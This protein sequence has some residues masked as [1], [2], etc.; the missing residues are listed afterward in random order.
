MDV[1]PEMAQALADGNTEVLSIDGVNGTDVGLDSSDELAIRILVGDPENPPGGLPETFG[2]FPAIIVAGD[3]V[4]D[5]FMPDTA[6][7][8][9]LRGGY[10][11]G[12]AVVDGSIS[13]GTLGCV[14]R[15]TETGEPVVLTAGHVVCGAPGDVIYQPAPST[16]PPPDFDELGSVRRCLI[17]N[18]PAFFPTPGMTGV[19]GFFDAAVCS[20]VDG[21]TPKVG[22]IEGIGT[23]TGITGPSVGDLV[24][25]RGYK[26][27]PTL[28]RVT[29]A[30]GT[31][32]IRNS[33]ETVRWWMM[34]Q[35]SIEAVPDPILNPDGV[36]GTSGDSGAV[37]VGKSTNEIV[38][39]HHASDRGTGT[40]YATD[41]STLA[42]A[43]NI[44]L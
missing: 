42:I 37:V 14:F 10:Q 28:G 24:R 36:W 30:V 40:G 23:A 38:A 19:S 20:I 4:M 6:R 39:M 35:V 15:D 44:S 9:P 1:P 21:R 31:Y 22:E 13:R 11:L 17:P 25:K 12:T 26:N 29:G 18:T 43:I 41:F 2:G 8:E 16:D 32:R 27:G 3:P 7:H 33:D 34:G 5:S